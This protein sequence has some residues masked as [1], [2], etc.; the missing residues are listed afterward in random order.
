LLHRSASAAEAGMGFRLRG[1]M[2][3]Q[4]AAAPIARVPVGI[5]RPAAPAGGAA[6][7]QPM[8]CPSG[9]GAHGN[10]D[11]AAV[12]GSRTGLVSRAL[13]QAESGPLALHTAFPLAQYLGL[14]YFDASQPIA[15]VAEGEVGTSGNHNQSAVAVADSR[16]SA[17]SGAQ[18]AA[19]P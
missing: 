17:V 5:L 3:S 8:E 16:A 6:V 18:R 12:S 1:V 10:S 19:S 9:D 11:T 4:E 13:S 7:T 15:A 14:P 2:S